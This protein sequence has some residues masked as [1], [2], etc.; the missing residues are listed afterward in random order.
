MANLVKEVDE[1]ANIPPVER[2]HMSSTQNEQ[3]D[4]LFVPST[5]ASRGLEVK[6][7]HLNQFSDTIEIRGSDHDPSVTKL[8]IC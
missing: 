5:I 8:N 1:V 2:Y 4:H 7:V 3:L 6:H